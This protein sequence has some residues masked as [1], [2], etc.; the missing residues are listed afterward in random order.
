MVCKN[1]PRKKHPLTHFC[2]TRAPWYYLDLL[3]LRTL[4][5]PGLTQSAKYSMELEIHFRTE[6][7]KNHIQSYNRWGNRDS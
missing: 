2:A 4:Q 1:C 7:E 3:Y 6:A 5:Q